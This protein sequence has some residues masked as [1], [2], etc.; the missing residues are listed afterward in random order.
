[1]PTDINALLA[2]ARR[3][4][5]IAG[6]PPDEAAIDA[7]LLAQHVLGWDAAR[8]LTHG[9]QIPHAEVPTAFEALVGRRA[10]REP[11]AYVIGR[12]DF[13]NLTIEVTPAVLVPRPET[14]LLIEAALE[15][16]GRDQRLRFADVCTGSGCVAVAL[17]REFLYADIVATDTCEDA[18]QVAC[19]NVIRHGL[20]ARLRCL[21]ADLL[22]CLGG[23]FD[24]VF[25]NPPYV[26]AGDRETLQPE[27]R[28]WEPPAALFGGSDGLQII[29]RLVAEAAPALDRNGLLI[30]E[31][32]A[33]QDSVVEALIERTHGLELVEIKPDLQDI[34]RVAVSRRI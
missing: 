22:K 25:A 8:L 13:W 19:R 12:R 10:A 31:F 1:M 33:G 20:A 21:R 26:P 7:R 17:G 23:P 30:F 4:F 28:K 18:L 29:R 9:D 6:I 11:L 16:F 2:D 34:P 24:A 27:V 5:R 3:R 15:Y 32:G 14:E